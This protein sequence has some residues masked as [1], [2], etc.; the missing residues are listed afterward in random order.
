MGVCRDAAQ[1][2]VRSLPALW[3]SRLENLDTLNTLVSLGRLRISQQRYA[4][5]ETLLKEALR[6][7]EKAAPQGLDLYACQ[8]MLGASLAG[9]KKYVEAEP[10]L[11]SGY[12]G[13]IERLEYIPAERRLDLEETGNQILSLYQNLGKPQKAAEWREKV[14]RDVKQN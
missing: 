2:N 7:Y 8:S 13:M 11:V 3:K 12:Q 1:C 9:Q 5:A 6:S 10:L 14:Q 4:D